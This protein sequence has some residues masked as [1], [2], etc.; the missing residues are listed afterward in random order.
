[1]TQSLQTPSS[2]QTPIIKLRK[3]VAPQFA[4]RDWA[5]LVLGAWDVDFWMSRPAIHP[6]NLTNTLLSV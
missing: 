4:I 2:K 6:K 1:V 5:F 3:I